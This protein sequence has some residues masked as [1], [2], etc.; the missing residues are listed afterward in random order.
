MPLNDPAP[1]SDPRVPVF[2]RVTGADLARARAFASAELARPRTGSEWRG[3]LLDCG[4]LVDLGAADEG[5]E[6]LRG[7]QRA[8]T[9]LLRAE[10]ALVAVDQPSPWSVGE[11]P[12]AAWAILFGTWFV[13][14]TVWNLLVGICGGAV[15]LGA[16][17]ILGL[18]RHAY[19]ARETA[20]QVL[21]AREQVATAGGLLRA[22]VL[23]LHAG[24]FPV[25]TASVR[26]EAR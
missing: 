10:D 20:Q 7:V 22:R 13:L 16:V 26:V 9:A 25:L 5:G 4:L 15:L 23:S 14:T 11:A 19:T 12:P 24:A 1:T 21:A 6:P 2:P 3:E 18:L 8:L 17:A